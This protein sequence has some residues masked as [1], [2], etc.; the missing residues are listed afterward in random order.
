MQRP[1]HTHYCGYPVHL[2]KWLFKRDQLRARLDFRPVLVRVVHV[3][4]SAE[5]VSLPFALN[6][7]EVLGAFEDLT[8]RTVASTGRPRLLLVLLYGNLSVRGLDT[9]STS[10]ENNDQSFGVKSDPLLGDEFGDE[11]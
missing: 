10:R 6:V 1:H 8:T 4:Q 7:L 11:N 3:A 5:L 2:L 9:D